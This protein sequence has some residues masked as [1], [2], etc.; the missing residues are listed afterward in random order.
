MALADNSSS[1]PVFLHEQRCGQVH[2]HSMSSCRFHRRASL[3]MAARRQGDKR[4]MMRRS[5]QSSGFFK[6]VISTI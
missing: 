2:H 6:I 1:S 5:F 3:N 4:A